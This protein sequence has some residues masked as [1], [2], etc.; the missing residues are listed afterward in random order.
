VVR[1]E[2][3]EDWMAGRLIYP[4]VWWRHDA[5]GL[6]DPELAEIEEQLR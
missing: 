1:F 2:W 3:A 5:A 6:R 4:D